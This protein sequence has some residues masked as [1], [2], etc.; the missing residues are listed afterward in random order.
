LLE[1]VKPEDIFIL[2]DNDADEETED[3]IEKLKI[4][5]ENKFVVGHKEF[6]DAFDAEVIYEAWKRFVENKGKRIGDGWT[7]ENIKSLKER[8]IKEKKKFSEELRKLN[9]GC[10]IS[11]KKPKFA[12]ALAEYC[13]EEH[14]PEDILELLKKLR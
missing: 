13:E 1:F 4:P 6:E 5:D 9:K 2:I 3:L 8:C 12:Q 7:I 11:M 14:L 10:P